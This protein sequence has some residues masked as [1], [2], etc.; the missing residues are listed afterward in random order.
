MRV[1]KMKY[2]K[3]DENGDSTFGSGVFHTGREAVA[4]A[5]L[6][7]LRLL[8]GEWWENTADGLPLFE[9]ILGVYG[10]EEARG[11]VDLIISERIQGTQDVTAVI[12]YESNFDPETRHYSA[13]CIVDTAFGEATFQLAENLQRIEVV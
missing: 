8:Y 5:I 2:R 10:G 11:A 3:L 1:I 9:R 4:Q 7:R 12:S 6:T 13:Y